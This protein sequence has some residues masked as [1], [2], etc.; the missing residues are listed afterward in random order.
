MG[1]TAYDG[2]VEA[3]GGDGWLNVTMDAG[4]VQALPEY[5]KVRVV[6]SDDKRE[7]FKILEGK[8]ANKGA[9]VAKKG[10]S[11][12]EWDWD[13]SYFEAGTATVSAVSLTFYRRS[14]KLFIPGVGEVSAIT[15]PD[16]PV[17]LGS[18]D[19]EIP[20]APHGGGLGYV[21]Q[22]AKYAKTWFRVGRS[23]DRYLHC[24]RATAGCITVTD[25]DQWDSI[26]RKLIRARKDLSS[27][28]TVKVLD[29]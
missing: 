1:F 4:G 21:N 27:V 23:G 13:E 26:Y 12:F 22:G 8:L 16:N 25:I 7:S 18:H 29:E 3:L 20:D 6:S 5:L 11:W 2:Y 24:G 19:L 17:P 10:W 15:H 14:G 9:S 28:G